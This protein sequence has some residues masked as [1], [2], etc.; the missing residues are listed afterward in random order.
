MLNS[1]TDEESVRIDVGRKAMRTLVSYERK[2]FNKCKMF[3]R[4]KSLI[5]VEHLI[6]VKYLINLKCLMK[7]ND[8]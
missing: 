7:Y 3:K 2:R 1:L 4:L 5:I 8:Y 6:S